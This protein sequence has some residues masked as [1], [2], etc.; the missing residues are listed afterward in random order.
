[1]REG[2]QTNRDIGHHLSGRGSRAIDDDD[3]GFRYQQHAVEERQHDDPLPEVLHA[4]LASEDDQ[5]QREN[6]DQRQRAQKAQ[7]VAAPHEGGDGV[8][9]GRQFLDIPVGIDLEIHR[10]ERVV[11]SAY[12]LNAIID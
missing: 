12:R 6:A 3:V 1:M 11:L 2:S 10:C 5:R 9:R 4:P 8:E 7:V